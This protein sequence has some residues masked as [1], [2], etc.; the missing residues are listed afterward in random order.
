LRSGRQTSK[1]VF[2]AG[3]APFWAHPTPKSETSTGF[4][5]WLRT[6]AE[7]RSQLLDWQLFASTNIHSFHSSLHDFSLERVNDDI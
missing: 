5:F 1:N 2:F 3:L 7:G 4:E 6:S